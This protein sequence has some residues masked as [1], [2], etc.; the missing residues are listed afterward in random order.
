MTDKRMALIEL[1][2][3]KADDDLVRKMLAFAA[4]RI[5]GAEVR[6]GRR[7]QRV[8]ER[9]CGRFRE[10][11]TATVTRILVQYGSRW[12]SQSSVRGATSPA[13]WNRAAQPRKP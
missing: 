8:H 10:T 6:R 12:K 4:K 1:I 5:I 9:R 13:F 7:P 11:D 2:E 3:K